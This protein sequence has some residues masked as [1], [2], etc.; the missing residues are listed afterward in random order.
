MKRLDST[1]RASDYGRRVR[2]RP[3]EE[4]FNE[5]FDKITTVKGRDTFGDDT[6]MRPFMSQARAARTRPFTHTPPREQS[7]PTPIIT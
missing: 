7:H 5:S 1:Q 4:D 3:Y 6:I 2:E